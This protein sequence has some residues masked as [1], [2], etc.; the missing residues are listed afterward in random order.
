MKVY[1]VTPCEDTLE[2]TSFFTTKAAAFECA[3]AIAAEGNEA[4]VSFDIIPPGRSRELIVAL[5]N[6]VGFSA[7]SEVVKV[8]PAKPVNIG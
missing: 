2:S 7:G 4:T 3:R 6:R 1:S 8:F 5:L